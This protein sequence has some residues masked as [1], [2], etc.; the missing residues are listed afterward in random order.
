[1]RSKKVYWWCK[2][3]HYCCRLIK[4]PPNLQSDKEWLLLLDNTGI[5]LPFITFLLLFLVSCLPD[6]DLRNTGG[7]SSKLKSRCRRGSCHE[8]NV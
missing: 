7:T 1:M 5:L 3:L 4:H 8:N 2:I 6:S